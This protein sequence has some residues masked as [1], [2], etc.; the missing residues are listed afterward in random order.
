MNGVRT[1][2][3]DTVQ[4][5][6]SSGLSRFQPTPPAQCPTREQLRKDITP[7][8]RVSLKAITFPANGGVKGEKL[9]CWW[10][11]GQ[12]QRFSYFLLWPASSGILSSHQTRSSSECRSVPQHKHQ[13][14]SASHASY[15]STQ[16]RSYVGAREDAVL[17]PKHYPK[18]SGLPKQKSG[19]RAEGNSL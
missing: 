15:A 7:W 5:R 10:A 1:V 18:R 13:A 9:P 16:G 17:V 2:G 6:S 11:S 4:R 8:L 12:E 14:D 3:F 19:S